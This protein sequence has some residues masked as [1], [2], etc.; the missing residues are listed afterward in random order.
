M[1]QCNFYPIQSLKDILNSLSS[2]FKEEK[3]PNSIEDNLE[4]EL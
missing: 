4:L 3:I 2:E 1:S